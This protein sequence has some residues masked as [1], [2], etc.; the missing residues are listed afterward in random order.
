MR[1]IDDCIREIENLLHE[2]ANL[3]DYARDL[4]ESESDARALSTASVNI[5]YLIN[6]LMEHLIG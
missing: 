2:A 1:T 3:A 6:H 4:A 5:H